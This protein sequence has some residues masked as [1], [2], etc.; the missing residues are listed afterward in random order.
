MLPSM[1]FHWTSDPKT[2]A[3][4]VH[5]V[6]RH[7][8]QQRMQP[9]PLCNKSGQF[10]SAKGI[11]RV[12]KPGTRGYS[13]SHW[14]SCGWRQENHDEW[15]EMWMVLRVWFMQIHSLSA[16]WPS[17]KR[18]WKT[19]AAS[20]ETD[21]NQNAV[22]QKDFILTLTLLSPRNRQ[23]VVTCVVPLSS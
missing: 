10:G 1:S 22:Y 23:N 14:T 9:G 21:G 4:P 17:C 15:C 7:L 2:A 11:Q 12:Q 3:V 16:P 13:E 6:R 5:P 8:G 18:P 19:S 20:G